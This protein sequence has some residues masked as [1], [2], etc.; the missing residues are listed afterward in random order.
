M[1]LCQT[2]T[3]I[4][5][6]FSCSGQLFGM[7][8]KSSIFVRIIFPSQ[9][10]SKVWPVPEIETTPPQ[11]GRGN[12]ASG[13][14]SPPLRRAGCGDPPRG[15]LAVHPTLESSLADL[16]RSSRTLFPARGQ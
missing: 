10:G 13:T 16:A 4:L 3:L 9:V 8:Q 2:T 12:G 1:T 11:A 6:R 15:S 5:F 14:G 7:H